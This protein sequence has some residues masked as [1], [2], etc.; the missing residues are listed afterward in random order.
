LAL[1]GDV[2]VLLLGRVEASD[3]VRIDFGW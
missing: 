2:Y 3:G 1:C